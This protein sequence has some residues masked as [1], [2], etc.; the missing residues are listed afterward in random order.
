[1]S[2]LFL[3]SAVTGMMILCATATLSWATP[4]KTDTKTDPDQDVYA[5]LNLFGEVFERI[6][7]GYVEEVENKQLIEAAIN[8]MLSSLDPHSSYLNA[9]SFKDMQVQTKG[10]F[11]GLGIEVTLEGGFVKVVSPIDGTPAEKAGIKAG[12]FITAL[13]DEQV[14][15]MTLQDAVEKMRGKIG[16]EIKLTVHRE[17]S[18]EPLIFKIKRDV[19][20]IR[21][22][23]PAEYNK[24][25]YIR[26]TTFNDN[27]DK[28][29]ESAIT[30]IKKDVG[31]DLKGYVIDLR[32][33]P[34]GLLDQAVAV[35]DMFLERGEIVSTRTRNNQ[36]IDSLYAET[37]K[38]PKPGDYTDGK[39]LVVLINGGSASASE[40]VAGALKE[41]KRAVLVGTKSFGKGSVQS[42]M[43]LASGD[44]ALR[45]T[46]A[47]YF[48]PSG[49]SIQATGILPDV[50]IASGEVNTKESKTGFSEENLPNHLKNE[51][52]RQKRE[53]EKNEK[54]SLKDKSDSGVEIFKD[55]VVRKDLQLKYAFDLMQVMPVV[56]EVISVH[57]DL[58][59]NNKIMPAVSNNS[60]K[61]FIPVPVPPV[62]KTKPI[63][64]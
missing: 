58:H 28:D 60:D 20:E 16:E 51:R 41:H 31:A 8:G 49:T 4:A 59:P 55:D 47:R 53:K 57:D 45:L 63:V 44:G 1:M 17:E 5:N 37:G 54:Q 13:N 35:S 33:N 38:L 27:T 52:E 40:I 11:G 7:A 62:D 29:L 2:G 34:G 36:K 22:V 56:K 25:G 64:K 24:I 6:K 43:P 3:R 42:I 19:I 23:R 46:T 9:D 26:I 50:E 30:K 18:K 32:N 10:E 15:G 14:L 39:P 61:T 48:T 21:A 12:D